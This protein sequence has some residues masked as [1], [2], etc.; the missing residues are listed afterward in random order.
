M[1]HIDSVFV[2]LA[3]AAICGI[4][5]TVPLFFIGYWSLHYS[6]ELSEPF[7]WLGTASWVA[8]FGTLAI[9]EGC[10]DAIPYL[11]HLLHL[12]FIVGAPVAG[13]IAVEAL[14]VNAQSG[15]EVHVLALFGGYMGLS[16]Q[17]MQGGLRVASTAATLGFGNPLLS[18]A[19]SI[20]VLLMTAAVLHW[21]VAAIV[22]V[23]VLF[24]TPCGALWVY[25]KQQRP[26]RPEDYAHLE[27]R[28]LPSGPDGRP[29]GAHEAD[30]VLADP[31]Q[32]IRGYA[33]SRPAPSAPSAPPAQV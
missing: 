24:C 28:S 22:V 9:A 32:A 1:E 30:G 12:A 3:L 16:L 19:E 33:D 11:D 23:V 14:L 15:L 27:W 7:Q 18:I 25:K 10:I 29:S 6:L 8:W 5:C 26:Y 4:R 20:A 2:G 17:F 31:G 21:P 13:A